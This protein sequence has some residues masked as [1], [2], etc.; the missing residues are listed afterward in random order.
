MVKALVLLAL[1]VACQPIEPPR[2]VTV[3]V[4]YTAV[5]PLDPGETNIMGKSGCD[6]NGAPVIWIHPLLPPE[7]AQ[8]VLVHERIHIT[9]KYAHGGCLPFMKKYREDR[10]FRLD[11]EVEAFCGTYLAQVAAKVPP[12]PTR[13]AIEHILH[14]Y[15]GQIW[16]AQEVKDAM[17]C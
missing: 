3:V 7:E 9:Q 16:S 10:S 6:M 12:N 1:A 8:W 13:D 15:Y 5:L 11:M 4:P 14:V 2:V 17:V